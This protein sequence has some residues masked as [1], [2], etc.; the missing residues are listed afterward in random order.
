MIRSN[1][2]RPSTPIA[3]DAIQH[4]SQYTH[5][6]ERLARIKGSQ[7]ITPTTQNFQEDIPTIVCRMAGILSHLFTHGSLSANQRSGREQNWGRTAAS[8]YYNLSFSVSWCIYITN[9]VNLQL[10]RVSHITGAIN[11]QLKAPFKGFKFQAFVTIWVTHN[12]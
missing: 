1:L 10:L 6:F 8:V 3:E 9:Q 7:H 4:W 11:A 12:F 5:L 2:R